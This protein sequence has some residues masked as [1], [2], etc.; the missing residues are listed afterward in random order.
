[1]KSYLRKLPAYSES[2]RAHRSDTSLDVIV[3]EAI[4]LGNN[5]KGTPEG[6]AISQQL[7]SLVRT[8]GDKISLFTVDAIVRRDE[9]YSRTGLIALG[10]LY[11]EF[12]AHVSALELPSHF[13]D[14]ELPEVG[15]YCALREANLEKASLDF[16]DGPGEFRF[17][18]L[19]FSCPSDIY[20]GNKYANREP[21]A[22]LD[23]LTPGV[24]E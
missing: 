17:A 16:M 5:L 10:I 24:T 13:V 21:S 14:L 23:Y 3:Q 1:M 19:E 20:F 4:L 12:F 7:L 8:Y 11:D 18:G 6:L 2:R 22:I 15:Y 9:S